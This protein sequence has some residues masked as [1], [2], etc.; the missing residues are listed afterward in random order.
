[1]VLM[2]LVHGWILVLDHDI[3]QVNGAC[4]L[5]RRLLS[6]TYLLVRGLRFLTGIIG[7]HLVY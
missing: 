5:H 4:R 6:G 7:Y 1:M 3:I 2:I